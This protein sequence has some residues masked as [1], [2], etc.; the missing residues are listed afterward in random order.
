M[1]VQFFGKNEPVGGLVVL[2]CNVS[3]TENQG[4]WE[5]AVL[6]FI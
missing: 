1:V 4:Q 6:T 5:Q 2:V 3:P